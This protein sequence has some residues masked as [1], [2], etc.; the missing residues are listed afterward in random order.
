MKFP[1]LL[2]GALLL[3]APAFSQTQ[4]GP[5]QVATEP[6]GYDLLMQA[7]G[8]ILPGPNGGASNTDPTI[9]PEENL[10]RERLAVA[11][12]APALALVRLALQKPVEIPEPTGETLDLK[13]NAR[14]REL[15]RQFS[16]ESDVRFA[17]GDFV[18]AMNSKLDTMELGTVVGH[19]ILISMLVGA[20]VESISTKGADQVASHLD[21]AQCH[22][23]VARLVRIE[24]RRTTLA[25]TL[26]Q[27]QKYN[28]RE[29]LRVFGN[30]KELE[31]MKPADDGTF[32][33]AQDIAQFKALTP[34]KIT[35]SSAR[36]F[37][38]VVASTQL[39]YPKA[40]TM[41]LPTDLDPWTKMSLSV[42]QGA[43]YRFGY[44]R[45][46]TQTRLLRAALELRSLKLENGAYPETF[47]APVDPFSPDAKPLVYRKTAQ[48]YLLY[49]VGP[50]GKDEGGAEIQTLETNEETGIKTSSSRLRPESTGDIVQ[51]PF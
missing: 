29:A 22:A 33:T 15:A 26:R 47:T 6:S 9:S 40:V 38:A 24:E 3:S 37:N 14:M 31:N 44:E 10:K 8:K 17:D 5:A 35:E 1:F 49:S 11:R 50:D 41:A 34:A 45:V 51:N 21:A 43:S 23:A 4:T 32:P 39:P 2:A 18:G 12:N 36:L 46:A 48:D 7:G 19:G 13:F 20:A 42:L 27:E 30:P 16:Q 25:D 28:L